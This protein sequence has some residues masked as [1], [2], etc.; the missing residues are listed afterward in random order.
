MGR[1]ISYVGA[2]ELHTR[3]KHAFASGCKQ[4]T[5]ILDVYIWSILVP[6]LI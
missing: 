1:I 5:V 2:K 6:Y 4:N 3:R